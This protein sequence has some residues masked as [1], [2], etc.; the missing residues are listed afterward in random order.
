MQRAA[1][2]H[3]KQQRLFS[4]REI[5]PVYPEERVPS[6]MPA[7]PDRIL[8]SHSRFLVHWSLNLLMEK[9]P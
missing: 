3:L 5:L 6:P 1:A 7:L 4:S 8:D 9:G 2:V